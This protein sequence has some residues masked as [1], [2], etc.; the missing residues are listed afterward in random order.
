MNIFKI[1]FKGLGIYLKN[2]V[3]L[4]SV[5]IFPVFGQLAGMA[6]ILVPTYFYSQNIKTLIDAN[7]F[8]DSIA[9]IFLLLIL[10]AL[11]GFFIFTKAFWEYMVV[12]VSLNTMIEAI[13]DQKD[14]DDLDIH[15]HAVKLRT[16]E[17]VSMLLLMCAIW[18]IAI[19]LPFIF[20]AFSIDPAIKSFLFAGFE[21]IG[22][23]IATILSIYL[24]LSFQVFAFE[25]LS[26]INTLKRSCR[27]IK[28]NFLRTVFLGIVLSLI[29]GTLI[30]SIVQ[31][32][33]QST[34]MIDF[35][36][37]P[38]KVYTA[39]LLPDPQV[40]YQ[41]ALPIGNLLGASDPIIELSKMLALSTVGIVITAFMLPLGSAC[42]TL[43]YQDINNRNSVVNKKAKKK[44][45]NV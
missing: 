21:F 35:I 17:Y 43:L 36:S 22:L 9:L 41:T 7:P 4:S 29:T 23:L 32:A 24:S 11:P 39:A 42:Y 8:F 44:T 28:G 38:F 1:F 37:Y 27:L 6:L 19:F 16:D 3:P 2:I 25:N 13:N 14:L 34:V 18:L 20:Y 10:I 40:L 45:K 30:P 31:S 15:T 5:M 26:P 33:V 12:S